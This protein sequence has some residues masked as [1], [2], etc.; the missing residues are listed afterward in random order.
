[1]RRLQNRWR[2]SRG[3]GGDV[4]NPKGNGA[5]ALVLGALALA[6]WF[7]SG[8]Y[9]VGPGEEAV[10]SRF[11]GY[12][13]SSGSGLHMHLP[14]PIESQRTYNVTTPNSTQ[15]P[16]EGTDEAATYMLTRDQNIASISF[17][18]LWRI[19]SARDFHFNVADPETAVQ[20]VAVSSMREVVGQRNLQGILTEERTAVEI[21]S[22]ELMQRTLGAYN[23]GV[24]VVQVQ[25]VG[26][27]PPSAVRPAFD[28]VAR[29]RQEAETA[30][31]DAT[32]YRNEVVPRARGEAFAA[33]QTATG[34]A[35]RFIS[36]YTQYRLSPQA[37]RDRLYY[38][39]MERVIGRSDL[40][41]IDNGSGVQTYLPLDQLRRQQAPRPA[42]PAARP[43]P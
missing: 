10:V 25:L 37:T 26:A 41:V 7:A 16:G 15:V 23:I 18:V 17:T 19:S 43:N 3:R 13:R 27:N 29:A 14:W 9:M 28:G 38:E 21:Q 31:N 30:I 39:T 33:E 40:R 11:G 5:G 42:E 35:Q 2:G 6:G 8:V 20:G 34:D 12:N 36:V 1:M 22:Q 32:R 4:D 24:E